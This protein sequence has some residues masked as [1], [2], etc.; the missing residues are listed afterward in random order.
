MRVACIPLFISFSDGSVNIFHNV[1]QIHG[2]NSAD[3]DFYD[4]SPLAYD[5]LHISTAQ[6]M[7]SG[8]QIQS[9]YV[10]VVMASKGNQSGSTR[11]SS[12]RGSS[13][14]DSNKRSASS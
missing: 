6:L 12:S 8:A 13:M 2:K 1:F 11:G 14:D 5:L 10:E 3:T 9:P 7:R 4:T